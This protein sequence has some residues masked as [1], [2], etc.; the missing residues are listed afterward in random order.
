MPKLSRRDRLAALERQREDIPLEP[1]IV[2]S[3]EDLARVFVAGRNGTLNP[4]QQQFIFDPEQI[5]WYCGPVGCAKTSTGIGHVVLLAMLFPGLRCLI[6]RWTNPS[7]QETTMKRFDDLCKNIPGIVIE[8]Q[9]GPP[10]KVW[11][12]SA[13]RGEN[14]LPM[15]PSEILF[16]SLDEVSKL[17]SQ[18]FNVVYVDEANEITQ[19]MANMLND[20]LRYIMP[21]QKKDKLPDWTTLR[22]GP[23]FL[24]LTSNPVNHSH[25]LHKQFCQ[26]EGC[27]PEP[28]GKKF[29]PHSKENVKNLPSGYYDRITK[30]K[31]PQEIAR[32]INGECGPDPHGKPVFTE[33]MPQ[34]HTGQLK[35]LPFYAMNRFWDFGRRRP[36]CVWQQ[37][38]P[39]G[40]YNYLHELLGENETTKAFA[41]RC[42]A[43][44]QMLFGNT[45][46]WND[47][48]DPAATQERS[49]SEDTDETV[50]F[51]LGIHLRYNSHIKSIKRG[52]DIQSE[53]LKTWV[54]GRPKVMIDVTCKKLID[55]HASGYK[56]PE[57]KPGKPLKE[58][59]VKDG[60][61][62]HLMDAKRYGELNLTLGS[63]V[64]LDQH[65]ANLSH[66]GH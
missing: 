44:S 28:M 36:A 3:V 33:F 63:N 35:F 56:W 12:S 20:R 45:R 32:F 54:N 25:W 57:E 49:N 23:Y 19:E 66:D 43:I 60:F 42:L 9:E 24:L 51:K 46:I 6:A 55:G 61:Y 11:I 52:L 40:H 47:Y 2:N 29:R 1:I 30:G 14:G 62:E 48:G 58:T 27:A 10:R 59:P 31:N 8:N 37:V 15:E 53:N 34:H 16:H 64:D 4:T 38:T 21:W 39:E 18:E 26:E 7:L 5:K 50:L 22:E 65:Y 41:T 17:G 13:R